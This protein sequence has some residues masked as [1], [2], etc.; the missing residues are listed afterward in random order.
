MPE[1]SQRISR[2]T[3]IPAAVGKRSFHGQVG[4]HGNGSLRHHRCRCQR[5]PAVRRPPPPPP[6][7]PAA[8]QT[9]PR[10]HGSFTSTSSGRSDEMSSF[11]LPATA[12]FTSLADLSLESIEF[13]SGSSHLLHRLLSSAC[14]PR[15]QR[16]QLRKLRVVIALSELLLIEASALLELSCEDIQ[17]NNLPLV[18]QLKTPSLQALRMADCGDIETLRISAAPRLEELIFFDD[19]PRRIICEAQGEL[20]CV[21][22]LQ[23]ELYS[24][25]SHHYVNEDSKDN[26]SICLLQCC[27]SITSLD[28]SLDVIEVC[29]QRASGDMFFL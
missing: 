5:Q 29:N 2:E 23:V 13:P 1:A 4:I 19:Q 17:G 14:C 8:A 28:V 25:K 18:L 16:L 21:R 11:H 20:S 15:L 10:V 9:N 12:V 24:H 22:S 3:P 26:V 7:A 6:P 27:T